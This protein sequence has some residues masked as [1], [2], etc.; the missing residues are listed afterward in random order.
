MASSSKSVEVNLLEFTRSRT[1]ES[2]PKVMVTKRPSTGQDPEPPIRECHNRSKS[3]QDEGP[4]ASVRTRRRIGN[5]DLLLSRGQQEYSIVLDLSKKT[6]N[7]T[8]G[9][10][11]AHCP[12]L[13][14]ELRQGI[15]TRRTARLMEV[16]P[17]DLAKGELKSPQVETYI[18][19]Q[20]ISGCLV[21]GGAVVN[22]MSNWLLD[23]LDL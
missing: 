21:D 6:A 1:L 19:K 7:I 18:D 3:R 8:I 5:E 14:R 4:S 10:L 22:V 13:R 20:R 17:T 16:R 15:S 23:D 9:Q 2:E 12:Y 11:I